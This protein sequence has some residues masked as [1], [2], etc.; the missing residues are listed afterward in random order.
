MEDAERHRDRAVGAL[1]GLAVGDAIG[2]P[3]EFARRDAMP[4][5]RDMIGGGHFSLQ[6]G[7]WTDDTAMALC[8]ADSI[9]ASGKLDQHDLL[10]RFCRWLRCGEN[11]CT[12]ASFSIGIT[13]YAAL[14]HY[15]RTGDPIARNDDP[16]RASNGSLMRLPPVAIHWHRERSAAEAMAR[17]QSITTHCAAAAVEACA[18]F[19]HLLLDAIEGLPRERVLRPREWPAHDDVAAI[20]CGA[21]TQKTRADIHSSGYVIHT[22]EAALWSVARSANFRDAV[23]TAANLGDDADTVAAVAGQLAGSLY[24]AAGIPAAWIE[25]LVWSE[26]IR[27]LG[28]ALYDGRRES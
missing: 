28:A 6:A 18:Y 13:T 26:R 23:L 24:G 17:Q 27:A 25:R 22:L 20:A 2:A 15:E 4:P 7:A 9:L 19:T 11:S 16:S 21:W 10:Q 3:R 14:E 12:G 1:L 8:L 5:L